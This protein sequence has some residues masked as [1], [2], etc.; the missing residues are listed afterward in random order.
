MNRKQRR[1][2]GKQSGNG[3]GGLGRPAFV[4]HENYIGDLLADALRHF[5]AGR[6]REAEANLRR[7]LA[8]DP[9]HV[10]GLHLLGLIA[11][12]LGRYDA[13]VA[14]ISRVVRIR[15]DF[16]EAHYNLGRAYRDLGALDEAEACYRRALVFKSD[17]AE[18]HMNLGNALA[19]QKK[20]DE[21][22]ACHRRA[23]AVKPDFA[24]AHYNL[25]RAYLG[26]GRPDD[27][28][29][30]CRNA[31]AINTNYAEAECT[32]GNA[33]SDKDM[34]DEAEA[35]YRRA[36]AIKPDFAEAHYN[37]GRA[38]LS[39]G[40]PAD[41]II[42]CQCAMTIKPN[43]AE[44]HYN[45]GLALERLNR[46]DE[47]TGALR[48]A[49][50]I[51][52]DYKEALSVLVK[53]RQQACDWDGLEA[54]IYRTLDLAG[55]SAQPIPPL[56]ILALKDSAA[57]HLAGARRWAEKNFACVERRFAHKRPVEER[58]MRLG[59]LAADFHAHPVAYQMTELIERHDRSRFE[60]IGYSYGPDDGSEVRRRLEK[61]FDRFIDAMGLT[62]E[63][64]ARR[65][66]ADGIDILVDLTGYTRNARTRIL[67]LRPAPIQ[68]N[69]LGYSGT[70]GADF[71]D[72]IIVDG[73]VAPPDQ[74]AFF[75]EKL[76]HLPNCF[77]PNDTTRHIAETTP[78]R[79]ECGL[80]DDAFVFCCFNNSYTITPRFFTLWMGLLA[81][82]PGSVLWLRGEEA[83]RRNLSREAAARG[84]DPKRLV[85]AQ[86]L[87]M[88][89]HLARYRQADLFLDTLP[90]N[91]HATACD[92]LWA[93]LPVLTLAGACFSG[94]VAGSLLRAVG[95]P[96]LVTESE[97]DY[98]ALAL[99]LAR[100]PALLGQ[101][102][103]R[104]ADKRATAPLFD[105]GGFTRD[106]ETAY[107][108]MWQH[109][110]NGD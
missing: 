53:L 61:A 6:L 49:L 25:G 107:Q 30:A 8:V 69:W 70:M 33:L 81:E 34:P 108:R 12:R 23:L 51:K 27:A 109:W 48:R 101:Y 16:P 77:M 10:D 29:A 64:L 15:P 79:A 20:L 76:V 63:D 44:A 110:R 96:E 83:V 91:A 21:A 59:Y 67:A 54:D 73:F 98:R 74:Q 31:L 97:E 106:I 19:E 102:R 92:A 86:G 104:L 14:L 85:F 41:A 90:Y 66:H 100:E 18:A 103:Q 95:L 42:S 46:Q 11:A 99:F 52:P 80:P 65:I 55:C 71:M 72:Y 36:L 50:A 89:E 84:I 56:M 47:A 35:C 43:H 60:V 58:R 24:E 2:A 93:G 1:I 57:L 32:L 22:V 40:R 62:D 38:F 75:T 17:F 105:A 82:L 5:Q 4:G 94:R 68:V 3:A 87:P 28:I 9:N 39:Q 13:A 26:Q 45:L 7:V 78:T 88:A 37:L